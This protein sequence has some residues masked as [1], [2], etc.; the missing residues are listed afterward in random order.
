MGDMILASKSAFFLQAFRRIG[1]VPDG[2]STW[3]LQRAV[4]PARARELT[5]MGERLSSEQALEWG[6]INRVYADNEL[7]V[8][9]RKLAQ[10]LAKGP[11]SLQMIRELM[12]DG[13]ENSYEEQLNAEREAQ[14]IAGRSADF[15]EGVTAFA[16]KRD[17]EFQGK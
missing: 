11:F 13:Q 9:T 8:E 7:P 1:L 6:M 14:R 3:L 12:W 10:E 5:M 15:K 16:E 2:G 4:G 17:A